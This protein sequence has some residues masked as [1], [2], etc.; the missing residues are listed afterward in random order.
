MFLM[1]SAE[2]ESSA[3]ADPVQVSPTIDQGHDN[4][5]FADETGLPYLSHRGTNGNAPS[6]QYSLNTVENSR[7]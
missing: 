6:A 2:K 3:I 5:T 1:R 4:T 7:L